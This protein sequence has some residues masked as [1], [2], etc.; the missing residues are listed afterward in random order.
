MLKTI[1]NKGLRAT[2]IAYQSLRFSTLNLFSR[3]PCTGDAPAVVSLTS[4]GKRVSAVHQ[5]IESIAHGASRPNRLILWLD[6]DEKLK[7][8]PRALQRL[9]KRG[10]EIRQ[11]RNF[12]PHKKYFPF[13]VDET[14]VGDEAL[15]TADDDVMYPHQWLSQLIQARDESTDEII[16]HRA[17]RIGIQSGGVPL[18]A[19]PYSEWDLVQDTTPSLLNMAT[20]TGGV[21]YPPIVLDALAKKGRAFEAELWHA[22]DLWLNATAIECGVPTRQVAPTHERLLTHFGSQ[23][24]ALFKRNHQ[25]DGNDRMIAI[26]YSPE[27]LARAVEPGHRVV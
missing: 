22:D 1:Y 19:A 5:T 6:E 14:R 3:K 12:G 17:R 25:E 10:L 4:Y 11:T 23:R 26:L 15:V 8:P 13:V 18:K 9:Q 2:K 16:A 20:G 21:L 27:L 24:T 7:N